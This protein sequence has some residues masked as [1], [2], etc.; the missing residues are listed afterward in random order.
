MNTGNINY[1]KIPK[2][3][4]SYQPELHR[5]PWSETMENAHSCA[6]LW[7]PAIAFDGVCLIN[8]QSSYHVSHAHLDQMGVWNS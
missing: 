1:K 6:Y 2:Y 3:I 8:S 7:F 4:I 5:N